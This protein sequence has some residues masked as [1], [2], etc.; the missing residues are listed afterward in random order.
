Y[1]VNSKGLVSVTGEQLMAT[2]NITYVGTSGFGQM[3]ISGGSTTLAFVSVGNNANGLLSVSGGQLTVN[4][5]TTNDW[6]Q[7]GNVGAG[8]F[9]LSG[10]SVVLFSEFH[11]GDDSSG[12]GTG[13]GTAS[14][15]GGQLIATSDVTAIGR[16]G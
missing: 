16:D 10:G 2:N 1:G 3:S 4:P 5:R 12:L 8:Q 9:N 7:I 13:S 14:S 15:T 11:V 6:A